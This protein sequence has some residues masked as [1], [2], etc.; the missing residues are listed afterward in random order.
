MYQQQSEANPYGFCFV[1]TPFDSQASVAIKELNGKKLT[2]SGL[3]IK[4]SGA[5]A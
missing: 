4:E 3:T 1:E 5:S 2:G